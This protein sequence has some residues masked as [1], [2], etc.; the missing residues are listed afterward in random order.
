MNASPFLSLYIPP[1]F[2]FPPLPL[3]PTTVKRSYQIEITS[4]MLFIFCASPPDQ[5]C[6]NKSALLDKLWYSS[7]SQKKHAG[8]WKRK[9]ESVSLQVQDRSLKDLLQLYNKLWRRKSGG[10]LSPVS[11]LVSANQYN[12]PTLFRT[13][14]NLVHPPTET[15]Q[16]SLITSLLSLSLW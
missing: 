5:G 6:H 1:D 12:P 15:P 3:E 11:L 8:E 10:S 14:Y 2:T 7:I 4:Q 16:P 9:M 13:I